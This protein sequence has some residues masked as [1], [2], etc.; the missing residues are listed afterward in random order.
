MRNGRIGG[1]LVLGG[2]ALLAAGMALSWVA[3]SVVGG[4]T[5][6]ASLAV[7]G[8]GAAVIA[9]TG[10]APFGGR[11]ARLWLGI[12]ALGLFG[13]A[14]SAITAARLTYDP[15]EDMPTVVL[16]LGGGL[17][18]FIG[19][20]LTQLSLLI[21]RGLA[22]KLGA[23]FF[24]G[25]AGIYLAQGLAAVSQDLA[26]LRLAVG[27]LAVVAVAVFLVG[28]AGPGLLAFRGDRAPA[29]ARG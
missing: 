22:R 5:M 20:L 2:W 7:I 9:I 15:L 21:A 26:P 4:A 19:M 11:L 6:S 10:P 23:L 24:A 1:G 8:S 3:G 25:F 14:G 13:V 12:L 17:A 28:C 16:L 29:V 18:T 27:L